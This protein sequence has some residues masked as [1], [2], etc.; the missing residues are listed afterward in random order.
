MT[1]REFL[2]RNQRRPHLPTHAAGTVEEWLCH[3]ELDEELRRIAA[4]RGRAGDTYLYQ[5]AASG[6][7]LVETPSIL[8]LETSRDEARQWL[9][10]S[11]REEFD[12]RFGS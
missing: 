8:S 12:Q 3:G 6:I 9:D 2:A 7:V 10:D 11:Q 5:T 1:L 4:F